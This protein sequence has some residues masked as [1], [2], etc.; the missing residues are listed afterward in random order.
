[1]PRNDNYDYN[2]STEENYC[3]DH[4]HFYG[5]YADIRAQL[6]YNYHSNYTQERQAF[7]DEIIEKFSASIIRD[8]HGFIG[9]KPTEPICVFTAGAMVR[10]HIFGFSELQCL[11]CNGKIS[12]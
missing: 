7:Q 11:I 5:P 1:M 3:A 8:K 6:D 10:Y 4:G 2:K 9:T 12:N